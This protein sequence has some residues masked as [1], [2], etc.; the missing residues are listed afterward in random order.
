M[1]PCQSQRAFSQL[2]NCDLDEQRKHQTA[3]SHYNFNETDRFG[4]EEDQNMNYED[5]DIMMA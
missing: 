3:Q 1:D 4:P 2:D 5:F